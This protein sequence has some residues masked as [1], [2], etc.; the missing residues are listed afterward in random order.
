MNYATIFDLDGTL[1]TCENKHKYVLHAILSAN[2]GIQPEKLDHWWNLKRN[3]YSTEK[4]L[5]EM[6]Y[7]DA[8]RIHTRWVQT[9]EN[10]SYCSLDK[11]FK[12]SLPALKFLKTKYNSTIIILTARKSKCKVLQLVQRYGFEQYLDE[13]IVV[14]PLDGVR[15]KEVYLRKMKPHVYIGDSES[16]YLAALNSNVRFIALSRGQRSQTFLTNFGKMHIEE[17]LQFLY[18]LEFNA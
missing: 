11:P 14:N 18:D 7:S 9:I 16:D 1:I 15:E 5:I 12:D 6:G 3:G 13:V 17:D 8:K 4:A 10:F 2:G